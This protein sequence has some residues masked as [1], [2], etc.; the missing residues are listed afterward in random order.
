MANTSAAAAAP[1]SSQGNTDPA[2]SAPAPPPFTIEDRLAQ[3][4]HNLSLLSA[5]RETLQAQI[6]TVRRDGQKADAA[7]RSEIEA[8]KRASEKHTAAEARAKQKILALQEAVKRAQAGARATEEQLAEIE[9]CLPELVKEKEK[10]EQ[11]YERVKKEAE[12]VRKEREVADEK[13]KKRLERMRTELSMLTHKLEK[14]SGKR[15]KMEGTVLPDLEE[16]LKQTR[17]ELESVEKEEEELA[18]EE[19]A[20]V[21]GIGVAGQEYSLQ[22][23]ARRR[24]NTGGSPSNPGPISRPQRTSENSVNSPWN[25]VTP[26]RLRDPV[27]AGQLDSLQAQR[28]QTQ[29][30]TRHDSL[31]SSGGLP[32][33]PGLIPFN[34]SDSFHSAVSSSSPSSSSSNSP[35]GPHPPG[36]QKNA[37]SPLSSRAPAFEPLRSVSYVAPIQRPHGATVTRSKSGAS[38]QSRHA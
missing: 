27:S 12:R 29:A 38:A 8:L 7:L 16:Q 25:S 33:P 10:R 6:K 28:L 24:A 19:L 9:N 31:R 23:F 15:E 34:H 2:A 20:S 21:S 22:G 17:Q 1:A 5:E 37:S 11:E 26:P 36:L 3:L 30:Q 35:T 13:D 32:Y 18:I 14:M 4:N